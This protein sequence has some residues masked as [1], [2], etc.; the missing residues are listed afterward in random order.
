MKYTYPVALTP[1]EVDGGFVVTCRDL[2]ETITQGDTLEEALIEATDA[3]DEAI[4]GRIK[5]GDTIAAPS[6]KQAGEYLASVSV[7]TAL[8]AAAFMRFQQSGRTKVAIADELGLPESEIRRILNPRHPTKADRL[9]SF[10]HALG[11][12]ITISAN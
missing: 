1:D 6:A 4:C 3:L 5:R 7:T 10:I 8:K 12:N 9:E 11:G 2:P